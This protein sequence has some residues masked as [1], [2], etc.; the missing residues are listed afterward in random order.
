[1]KNDKA[2]MAEHDH[3]MGRGESKENKD[4]IGG[5]LVANK[6]FVKEWTLENFQVS[7]QELTNVLNYKKGKVVHCGNCGLA[8]HYANGCALGRR[9]TYCQLH[10]HKSSAC[11]QKPTDVCQI[12]QEQGHTAKNCEKA[13]TCQ[14]CAKKGHIATLCPMFVIKGGNKGLKSYNSS[15][16]PQRK[17]KA[18]HYGKEGISKD[19]SHRRKKKN[20]KGERFLYYFL[21]SKIEDW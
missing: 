1:M 13:P 6:M 12:C 11:A 14:L 16:Q 10:S 2:K 3:E 7:Y 4:L 8:G 21:F 18:E 19:R 5:A 20:K 17:G 9:C 15:T